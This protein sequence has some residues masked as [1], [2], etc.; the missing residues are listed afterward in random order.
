MPPV[1]DIAD[2][3][4]GL[5]LSQYEAAFRGNAVDY[6]TLAD[7]SE[8]DLEKLGVLL[9]HRKKMLRSIAALA[10]AA[11]PSPRPAATLRAEGGERRQITV[12]FCD[13]VA[14]TPLAARLDPEDLREVLGAYQN[15]VSSV[16]DRF[17]GFVARYMGDGML[18]YF[19]YPQAHED[20][21]ER[22]VRAGLALVDEIGGLD[23]PS[24]DLQS[25][26]G[27]ATGLV[28][29]GDLLGSGDTK[30]RDVV[31]ET[32]NLAARLQSLAGPNTVLICE[33]TRRLVGDL[34][35]LRD[36]GATRIRGFDGALSVWQPIRASL[37]DSRF[38]ALRSSSLT[39]LV[40]REEEIDLL[41]RRWAAAK[42]GRGQIVLIGGEAGIGKSRLVAAFQ[43]RLRG[44]AFLRL[45]LSCSPHHR[46]SALHPVIAHLERA[47]GFS[48]D[49]APAAKMAKLAQLAALSEDD[50]AEATALFAD[51]LS[52]PVEGDAPR[53][54]LDPQRKR[55]LLFAASL[56]QFEGLARQQPLLEIIEDAHWIDSTSLELL[57]LLL[58]RAPRLPVLL[59]VTFRSEFHP[60][61]EGRPHVTTLSLDRL[62]RSASTQL[63]EKVADG[64]ALPD[65]IVE[66]IVERTDGIPLFVEELTKSLL[67]GGSLREENGRY[68]LDHTA[69]AFG[70][71][72]EPARLAA[73]A[74]RPA[75]PGQG[76]GADRRRDR[77][78]IFLRSPGGGGAPVMIPSSK[79]RSS[80]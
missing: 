34:F 16:V 63:I 45:R 12:M 80:S 54:A 19:G 69:A 51:L 72:V 62:G 13:L 52:V 23:L 3:L 42:S 27:I 66:R 4:R 68:I 59:L 14:S 75:R 73:G 36:L 57:D 24:G 76:G 74:P 44:E 47:A 79:T 58:E 48:R 65:E 10:V 26:V 25:R 43:D 21:A 49:D 22:A 33:A 32:P 18:I 60:P 70:D 50:P 78:R 17:G 15:L 28:V 6:D 77:P 39:P 30:E 46:D 8:A 55:E 61:W 11:T 35:E 67:E 7:L 56:R 37:H 71:P 29:V 20:D 31:G 41:L 40:G 9:G 2:W 53:L 1:P 38:E 5:G 64:K